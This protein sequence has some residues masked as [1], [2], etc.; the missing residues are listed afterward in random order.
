MKAQNHNKCLLLNI[1]YSPLYIIGW[2]RALTWHIKYSYDNNYG[3]DILDFYQNDHILGVNNKKYPVPS[4]AKTK[5]FF[6]QKQTGI[7]FSRKNL[8]LRDNY[9]CQYCNIQFDHKFLTYDHVI[10]KS[11]W[12][13][14]QGSPTTWTNIVTS[15]VRCNLKKGNKTPKQANMPLMNIPIKP[16]KT[17]KYLP[18][19][20]ILRR[21]ENIP[22]EW[23]IYLP[24]SYFES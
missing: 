19:S 10:P 7:T 5:F 14:N 23:S 17:H 6:K 21:L 11:K 22:T 9:T 15:C 12:N 4:V 20:H 24:P 3:I 1:D 18:I 16:T 2:K 13:Y 8:F